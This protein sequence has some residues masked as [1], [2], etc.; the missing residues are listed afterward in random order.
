[1]SHGTNDHNT[2]KSYN[3]LA[4][5]WVR[6]M[7]SCLTLPEAEGVTTTQVIERSCG[8]NKGESSEIHWSYFHLGPLQGVVMS[9]PV[10]PVDT[11]SVGGVLSTMI[12]AI[13]VGLVT[14]IV[15]P[16]SFICNGAVIFPVIIIFIFSGKWLTAMNSE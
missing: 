6:K 16:G 2:E 4:N 9:H 13:Q 7:F 3:Y 11:V 10:L 8:T 12:Q 5:D 1:M 15:P 14:V